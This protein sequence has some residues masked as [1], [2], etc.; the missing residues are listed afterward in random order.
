M[1]PLRLAGNFPCWF[2]T[3]DFTPSYRYPF[4]A[5]LWG[6]GAGWLVSA[7]TA[8]AQPTVRS[9]CI[10]SPCPWQQQHGATN[11]VALL[12]FPC[13]SSPIVFLPVF[14]QILKHKWTF[15]PSNMSVMDI[16]YLPVCSERLQ[17][18]HPFD[19]LLLSW[20]DKGGPPVLVSFAF[21]VCAA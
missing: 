12:S 21:L 6:V 2:I 15:R 5:S 13:G 4:L 20:A 1:Q 7:C 3:A 8:C 11:T 19:L 16:R 17:T 14:L 9:S 18:I 10:P